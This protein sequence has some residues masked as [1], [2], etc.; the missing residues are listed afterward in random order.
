[1]TANAFTSLSLDP[2]LVLFCVR[3]IGHARAANTAVQGFSVNILAE[4]Q[5]ALS[6]YFAGGCGRSRSRRRFP[7]HRGRA[8]RASTAAL[9]ALGCGGRDDPRGR[10]SLDR[11]RPR[12]GDVPCEP[13]CRPLVH[14]AGRYAAL[15]AGSDPT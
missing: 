7:S 6:A 3:K 4:D 14:F 2:P 5:Q 11:R 10:R 15:A 9:A 8:V 13:P 12:A 1:M